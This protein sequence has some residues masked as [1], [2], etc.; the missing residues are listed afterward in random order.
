MK[1]E[2]PKLSKVPVSIPHFP[3][4]ECSFVF[5][6]IKFFTYEK[7]AK[8]LDTRVETKFGVLNEELSLEYDRNPIE[9]KETACHLTERFLSYIIG[10]FGGF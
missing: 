9:I 4:T 8:V 1:F 7:I 5:R 2:L 6:T 3:T 10:R